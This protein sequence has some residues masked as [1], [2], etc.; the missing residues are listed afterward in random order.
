MG[1]LFEM[2]VSQKEI[3]LLPYPFSDLK[4]EKVRPALIVSNDVFNKKCADCI[5]VPLTSVIKDEPYSVLVNQDDMHSG[6]LVTQS[7]IKADKIFT[8]EKS[9]I[10]MKIGVIDDGAFRKVKVELL[11]IF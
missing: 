11:K 9:L 7:R 3:V 1:D 6:R 8:V 5:M 4:Q 10:I 2:N